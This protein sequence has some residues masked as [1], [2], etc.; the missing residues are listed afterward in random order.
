M[1]FQ[2]NLSLRKENKINQNLEISEIPWKWKNGF[3]SICTVHFG[4][5]IGHLK[6]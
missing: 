2:N 4:Q 5:T 3:P 6:W 1:T